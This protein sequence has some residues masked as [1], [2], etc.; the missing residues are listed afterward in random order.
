MD[1]VYVLGITIGLVTWFIAAVFVS[2]VV[3]RM[4]VRRD[5]DC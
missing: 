1:R 5:R 3:G 4:I 2:V